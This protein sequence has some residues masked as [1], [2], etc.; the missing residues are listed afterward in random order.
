[1]PAVLFAIS[2]SEDTR[3]K[4]GLQCPLSSLEIF[5]WVFFFYFLF[6]SLPES[7]RDE[8]SLPGL[9]EAKL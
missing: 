2:F 7:W 1:M 5:P 4:T 6:S 8:Y 3:H 9:P